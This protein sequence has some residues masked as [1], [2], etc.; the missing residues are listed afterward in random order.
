MGLAVGSTISCNLVSN[1]GLFKQVRQ[2]YRKLIQGCAAVGML[3]FAQFTGYIKS[4]GN[5]DNA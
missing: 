2:K 1:N 5:G 3:N 4:N